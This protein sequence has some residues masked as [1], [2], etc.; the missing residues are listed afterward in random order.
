MANFFLYRFKSWFVCVST[1]TQ[2][3]LKCE[4]DI[5][6][7]FYFKSSGGVHEF[8]A[9]IKT[10]HYVTPHLDVLV[11]Y[12]CDVYSVYR[13]LLIIKTNLFLVFYR[14]K[15]IK[16]VIIMKRRK[17]IRHSIA[18]NT[19]SRL[20]R[21]TMVYNIILYNN[22]VLNCGL[23]LQVCMFLFD[24]DTATIKTIIFC[25]HRSQVFFI[26]QIRTTDGN[27]VVWHS[28]RALQLKLRRRQQYRTEGRWKLQYS[29][30]GTS[31]KVLDVVGR[32]SSSNTGKVSSY[33]MQSNS[34]L[35]RTRSFQLFYKHISSFS[36]L[37]GGQLY[38]GR[39][40]HLQMSCMDCP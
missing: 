21:S 32:V 8:S 7:C 19:I 16:E 39:T 3:G 12:Y 25:N 6:S 28:A 18:I 22:L 10:R 29:F 15:N 34:R 38:C 35:I 37:G 31:A 4:I 23:S 5:L 20:F 13:Q 2:L 9:K 14:Q 30:W 26:D 24:F 40:L 17:N 27:K 36:P 11:S 1:N 33:M